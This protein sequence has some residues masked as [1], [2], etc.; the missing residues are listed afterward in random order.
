MAKTVKPNPDPLFVI[1]TGP[2]CTGKTTLARSL[3]DSFGLP[4]FYKDGY[5]EMM[6]DLAC[7]DGDYEAAIP[8]EF[9]RLL[10]RFS[11]GCLE[12][13]MQECAASGI[14]ALFEANFDRALFSPRLAAIRERHPFAVVQVNLRCRGDILQKRFAA[15]EMTD[16]H[17]G[18]GG[19][20]NLHMVRSGFDTPLDVRDTDDLVEIDTTDFAAIDYGPL[21]K[22]IA[23][24]MSARMA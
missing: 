16:R 7:P 1:I 2:S 21:N 10:G 13:S 9:S 23:E 8:R 24:R 11:L 15:R 6:F 5:K 17:P 20:R 3:S 19:K 22:I 4:L 14:S 18:H 12:I